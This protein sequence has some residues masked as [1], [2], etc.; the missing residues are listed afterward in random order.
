[1][2]KK[3]VNTP[4]RSS[5]PISK[6]R[7]LTSNITP[8]RRERTGSGWAPA[9]WSTFA[10]IALVL[11]AAFYFPSLSNGLVNWDDEANLGEN[12]N[13]ELV[14][15]GAPWG[16][17]IANIFDTKKGAVIGNYNP[18]PILTFAI[19]KAANKGEFSPKLIHFNNLLLHLLTTFLAMVLL[20]R[21]GL[22]NWGVLLG[23]LL[24]GLH[25]MRVESVAWATERKDVLFAMFFFASLLCYVTYAKA[26]EKGR[27]TKYYLLAFGFALLSCLSKVQGVT[28]FLS[29]FALDYF[30]AR[31]MNTKL[32][33]EKIPF[34]VLFLVFGLIN[35]QTLAAQGSFDDDLTQFGIFDR[36][37]IGTSSF[38]VYLYKL[39]LP[40]PMSP[41]YPYPK[42]IPLL[43][44]FGPLGM[45]AALALFVWLV[46]RKNRIAVFGTAFF[47]VNVMFLLQ[48]KGAGQGFLADRFTYVPYF[49]L[50]AI[51][52]YYFD[53]YYR[54]EKYRSVL[55][56]A[57]VALTLIYGIWTVQQVGIWKNGG[58]LWTHVMKFEKETNSLP[59][60]NRGQF[61]RNQ[62]GNYNAAL[63][64]YTKAIS[65]EKSNPELYNS[66]GKTYF[67]MATSG[68]FQNQEGT[69]VQKALEDY[70]AA[71][72]QEKIKKKT[73]SEVLINRGAALGFLEQ[74]AAS[75]QSLDEGIALDSTNKNGYFNRSIALYSLS[76]SNKE[77]QVS[78]LNKALY[79]Y[80]KYLQL[81]PNNANV[82]YESGMIQRTLGKNQEALQALNQAIRI[83]P[84]FALA[85]IERARVQAQSGNKAAAQQ[86]FQRAQLLGQPMSADDAKLLGQ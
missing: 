61:N 44:R 19:E 72:G 68:K 2:A 73:R 80:K 35:V 55:Q 76:M 15:K 54:Q 75:I 10:I 12:P 77:E 83:N 45:L 25:P 33:V 7:P 49:G 43:M 6:T 58:T 74:F 46:R 29:M 28:L 86:D 9:G 85:F 79:D 60:V 65:I 78:Y 56:G 63:A 11:T 13:L 66:R 16:E 37:C 1:M 31:P 84:N 22:G 57:V 3:T 69:L 82:W 41:L 51:A 70:N 62:L 39:F 5:K 24:F 14:G 59:Y 40:Y 4:A 34:F 42:P 47:F 26:T 8:E 27:Q 81:D 50:F 32:F 18:L 21:M 17:T 20:W 30:W 38:C 67:D 23:G 52:A 64:D 53:Q 48:W 36:I 71:L